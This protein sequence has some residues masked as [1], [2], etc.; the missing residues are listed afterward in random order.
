MHMNIDEQNQPPVDEE[1]RAFLQTA[2][3]TAI[4]APA[5]ALLL[6]ASTMPDKA[7]AQVTSGSGSG[8]DGNPAGGG[9]GALAVFLSAA[10]VWHRSRKG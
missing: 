3:K 4:V 9:I 6:A 2:G 8:G 10:A 7:H 5:A 1:R